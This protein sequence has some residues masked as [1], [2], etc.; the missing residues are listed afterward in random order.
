MFLPSM[1]FSEEEGE[2]LGNEMKHVFST[3][4]D[5]QCQESVTS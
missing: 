3:C 2:I 1:N 5:L 4:L